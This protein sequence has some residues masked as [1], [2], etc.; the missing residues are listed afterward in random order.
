[1]SFNARVRNAQKA[2]GVTGFTGA[3]PQVVNG[4]ALL[5]ADVEVN[6]LSALVYTLADTNTLTL[7]AAWQVSV[8]NATWVDAVEPQNPANVVQ[9]TGTAGADAGI[10]RAITAPRAVYGY[11]YARVKVTSGVGVGGGAGVDECNISY[12]YLLRSMI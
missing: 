6:S 9:S 11:R 12:S 3:A 1:M 7:T 5:M 10:T 4:N 8:D 2:T